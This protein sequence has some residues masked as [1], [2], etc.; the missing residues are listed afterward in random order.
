MLEKERLAGWLRSRPFLLLLSFLLAVLLLTSWQVR[1]SSAANEGEPPFEVVVLPEEAQ[2]APLLTAREQDGLRKGQAKMDWALAQLVDE[3]AQSTNNGLDSGLESYLRVV[4]ERV[5]VR[6]VS[7]SELLQTAEKVVTGAGGVVTVVSDLE[8][9]LQ[10]WIPV[11]ELETVAANTAVSTINQ[12]AYVVP[13]DVEDTS[14]TSEGLAALNAG[15][16]HSTGERGSGVKIAIID[17]GFQ[18]YPGLLG[19]NLPAVVT[20]K[21]FVDGESDEDVKYGSPHGTA[22]AEIAHDIVPDAQFYLIKIATNL[23]LQQAVNYA[24]SQGVDVISTSVG[25]YNLTPGDG[26]GQFADLAAL[27]RSNGIIW[28]TAAGNDREAHWGGLFNDPDSDDIHDFIDG[29]EFNYFGPGNG[30][31]YAI[32]SGVLLRVFVRWDDWAAVNQD[33][34]LHVI[35]WN[36]ASRI[37]EIVGSSTDQQNGGTGQRPTEDVIGFTNGSARPYGFVI[38]RFNSSRNVNLEIFAPKVAPLDEIVYERSLPNLADAPAAVTVG[39][40]GVEFPYSLQGYSAQ[41][42]TNGPGGSLNG[43]FVKPDLVAYTGVSTESY[44]YRAFAG[45]SA[46]APHVAGAAALVKGAYPFY[47]PQ[48]IQ[49]FLQNRAIDM[50]A[51][52]MDTSHGY[53]RAFL[54]SPPA[55]FDNHIYLP[56][57]PKN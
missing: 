23:D 33:Y 40:V 42:P 34:D 53:G 7:T 5:Q 2:F 14:A 57:S 37:W 17:G 32:P 31:A 55:N 30:D 20:A 48:L 49:N 12:P 41:G 25:W 56:V 24:I 27:A 28:A 44:G 52:G 11:S 13:L 6:V 18:G 39:A 15:V 29:Q 16:W 21:N 46:S 50:G 38:E 3:T 35:A 22:C 1:Q 45:T 4:D 43:G 51:P 26:T 19:S 54:G 8:P 47:S 10:A 36:A 9:E